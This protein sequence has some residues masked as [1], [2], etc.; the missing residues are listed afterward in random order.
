MLLAAI[1]LCYRGIAGKYAAKMRALCLMLLAAI[2]EALELDFDYLNRNVG[3]QNQSMSLNY[4]P[5]YPSPDHTL[6]LASHT[7]TGGISVLMARKY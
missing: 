4:Y 3:K 7:D 1:R 6:G 2:S 5:L